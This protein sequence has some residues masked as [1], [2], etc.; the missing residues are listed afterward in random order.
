MSDLCP[1]CG[2][3][4]CP[5]AAMIKEKR[6]NRPTGMGAGLWMHSGEFDAAAT[7]CCR[8]MKEIGGRDG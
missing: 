8:R 3:E 6:R 2:T 7:E 5:K 4:D 1:A